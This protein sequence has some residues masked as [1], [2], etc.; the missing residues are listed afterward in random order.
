MAPPPCSVSHGAKTFVH[1][2]KALARMRA[3]L[4]Q[5]M[6]ETADPARAWLG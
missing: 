5:R 1:D 6:K 4:E 2:R 3:L